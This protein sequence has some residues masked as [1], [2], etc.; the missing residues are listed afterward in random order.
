MHKLTQCLKHEIGIPW[1]LF[2][3]IIQMTWYVLDIYIHIYIHTGLCA[4]LLQLCLTLCNPMDCS[5][6]GSSVHG[7]SGQ[8]YWNGLPCSSPRTLP[9]PETK[10][11]SPVSPASPALKAEFLP[12]SHWGSH[13]YMCIYIYIMFYVIFYIQYRCS[14][15]IESHW[16]TEEDPTQGAPLSDWCTNLQHRTLARGVPLCAWHRGK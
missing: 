1:W 13:V 2:I 15:T 6:P 7:I 11:T 3:M 10:F 8:E 14:W 12:L 9:K 4:P 5:P 16:T